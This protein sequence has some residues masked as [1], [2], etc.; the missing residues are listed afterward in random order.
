M[1]GGTCT[2]PGLC[3]CPAGFQGR[4][5]EGGICSSPCQNRGKCIQAGAA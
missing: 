4:S 2:A 1:N 3:Q 5:C